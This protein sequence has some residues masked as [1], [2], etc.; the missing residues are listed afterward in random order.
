[1]SLVQPVVCRLVPEA[2]EASMLLKTELSLL[3][4][5]SRELQE[6]STPGKV[7]NYL[8][9]GN[10]RFREGRRLK[11]DFS[12]QVAATAASQHP[13]AVVLSGVDSRT[14]VEIIFDLGIGD[15]FSVRVA[16]S[17][18]TPEVLGSIEFWVYCGRSKVNC[19]C[20]S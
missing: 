13:M 18:V 1:M 17:I 16:G 14:P 4:F 19:C 12:R 6:H 15:V 10:Q 7:L 11:R 2:F 3:I 8:L 5:S 20:W 9:V